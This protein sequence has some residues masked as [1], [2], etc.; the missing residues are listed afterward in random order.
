[1]WLIIPS[2]QTAADL[3]GLTPGQA[4]VRAVRTGV[5]MEVVMH[6]NV[7]L[8][9]LL[10]TI[11]AELLPNATQTTIGEVVGTLVVLSRKMRGGHH[12]ATIAGVIDAH[13]RLILLVPVMIRNVQTVYGRKQT[14]VCI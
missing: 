14:R 7:T 12:L 9:I 10:E 4:L 3:L 8:G 5:I 1:M 2:H 11:V 13:L 6:L